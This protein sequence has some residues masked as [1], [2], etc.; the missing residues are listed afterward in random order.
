MTLDCLWTATELRKATGGRLV[1]GDNWSVTGVSIDSRTLEPGDLFVAL[2]GPN[3]D[4]HDYVAAA[5][6]SGAAGVLVEQATDDGLPA[7][8]VENSSEALAALGLTARARSDA[9]IIAVTGSVGKTSTKEALRFALGRGKPTHASAR[10]YNNDIGVPLSLARMPEH[11]AFG[12]FEIGMNH[13]GEITPLSRMVR[14]HVV[15]ITAIEEVH[16]E[17]FDSIEDIADAKAEIF[18][19][20]E[21]GGTAILNRDNPMFGR[22]EAAARKAGIAH[23]VTFGFS[24]EADVYP[25]RTKILDDMSCVTAQVRDQAITYKVGAPGR[26]WV[27]N[28][29]AI[30]AA[31][32][33]VGGDLGLA[34]LALAEMAPVQGRGQRHPVALGPGS[35]FWV[36]DESYNA[37]P[38]SMRAALET[39]GNVSVDNN[40]RRGHGRAYMGRRIAILGDMKE[41]GDA[42]PRMHGDLAGPI[43]E[44][45]IDLV[46]TVGDL[47]EHLAKRLPGHMHLGHAGRAREIMDIIRPAI[48]PNDVIMVKGSQ[49]MGMAKIVEALMALGQKPHAR[50]ARG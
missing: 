16:I 28:S 43:E 41:L 40:G 2:K 9:R 14:P 15:I 35:V 20:L 10:S 22:L 49:S 1:G 13:A 17:F 29:L 5:R 23:I 11:S 31:V 46:V 30:L 19:G 37:N 34:G 32:Q 24:D 50:V 3:S 38:A 45:G 27:M 4:G 42:G 39:L 44:N 8:V 47:M 25:L 33:A 21:E 36:I 7:L 12:V 6:E 48:E 18:A 26:H